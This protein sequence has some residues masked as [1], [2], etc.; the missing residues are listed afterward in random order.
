V[1]SRHMQG[2]R[3]E[4]TT[5]SLFHMISNLFFVESLP[6]L[7]FHRFRLQDFA[8]LQIQTFATISMTQWPVSN[9]TVTTSELPLVPSG[10]YLRSRKATSNDLSEEQT[11]K[12]L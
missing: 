5:F 9:T 1:R 12:L 3:N 4:E 7:L 10:P 2:C 6:L 11:L 8:V